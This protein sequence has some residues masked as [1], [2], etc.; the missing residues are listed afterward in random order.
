MAD[1][2]KNNPNVEIL[3]LSTDDESEESKQKIGP[4]K[5]NNQKKRQHKYDKRISV[6][7]KEATERGKILQTAR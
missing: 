2:E 4:K 5:T 7:K 6:K 3:C 1:N